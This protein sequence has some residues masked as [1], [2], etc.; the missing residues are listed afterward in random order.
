METAYSMQTEILKKPLSSKSTSDAT[1]YEKT[2]AAAFM[3]LGFTKKTID[4]L[5]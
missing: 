1:I 3:E 4:E 5:K 2:K